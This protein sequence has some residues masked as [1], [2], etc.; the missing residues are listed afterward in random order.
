MKINFYIVGKIKEPYIK[1]AISLYKERI[2]HY[3][4]FSLTYIDESPLPLIYKKAEVDKALLEEGKRIVKTCKSTDYKILL[5]LHGV[6]LSSEKFADKINDI[7]NK[8]YSSISFIIGS[9][10]GISDEV[11]SYAD[12]RLK[13]SDMTFTHP[14][15]LMLIMEQ[16]YRAFKINN[17][18][19]YH[20]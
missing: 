14:Q 15:T 5:D 8:S 12:Y 9:S 6:S 17:N 20:K 19:T 16:V 2:S 10:Y 3:A 4:D 13:I 7:T 1:N 18:E 11:R